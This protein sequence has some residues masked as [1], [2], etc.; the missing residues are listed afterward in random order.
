M[1]Q[2][3]AEETEKLQRLAAGLPGSF[4]IAMTVLEPVLPVIYSYLMLRVSAAQLG[5][6]AMDA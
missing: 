4:F 5:R 6:S 2:E 1:E 3:G